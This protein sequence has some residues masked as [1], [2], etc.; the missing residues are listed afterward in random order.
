MWLKRSFIIRAALYLK[1]L[2]WAEAALRGGF[3]A[4]TRPC[5]FNTSALFPSSQ[6]QMR[7]SPKPDSENPRVTAEAGEFGDTKNASASVWLSKNCINL[8]GTK[9]GRSSW[10]YYITLHPE[11]FLIFE[12]FPVRRTCGRSDN[13]ENN[14]ERKKKTLFLQSDYTSFDRGRLNVM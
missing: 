6:L 4:L 3:E 1:T 9:E 5:N 7:C 10:R 2:T 12:R 8:S 11:Q 14:T 13:T